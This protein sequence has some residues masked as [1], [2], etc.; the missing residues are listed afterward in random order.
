M[1]FCHFFGEG[2]L[3]LYRE[4]R[5]FGFMV[6]R[7][8]EIPTIYPFLVFASMQAASVAA[9]RRSGGF[10]YYDISWQGVGR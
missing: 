7:I 2:N 4:F 5:S 1:F 10:M 9:L 3:G 8:L 6:V